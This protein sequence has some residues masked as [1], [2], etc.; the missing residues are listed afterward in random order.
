MNRR[1]FLSLFL[2]LLVLFT[3]SC[4]KTKDIIENKVSSNIIKE[5]GFY[6]SKEDVSVY[7]RLYKK[8]PNNYIKKADARDLGWKASEGNLWDVTEKFSIGGDKFGNR[9]K[10]LP[11]KK[12]R[13][14]FECDIDYNGGRRNA[15]RIVFSNDGLIYYTDDHYKSFEKIYGE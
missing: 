2:S 13:K 4:D 6:S 8:L 15:K 3:F 7:I 10:L 14:Y 11:I 5:D 1:I 12:G 9:E